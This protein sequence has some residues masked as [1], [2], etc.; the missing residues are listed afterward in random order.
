MKAVS[1]IIE[2]KDVKMQTEHKL[3]SM[4][5]EARVGDVI[6][7]ERND[8]SYEGTVFLVRENSVLVDISK[9]ASKELGYE[10][11]NTVVGHGKYLIIVHAEKALVPQ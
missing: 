3:L 2:G 7:F 8:Q 5:R 11:P 1:I 10:K 4:N 9:A 6:L